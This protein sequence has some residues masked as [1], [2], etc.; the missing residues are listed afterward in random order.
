MINGMPTPHARAHVTRDRL[1]A[2]IAAIAGRQHG[3]LARGQ[4]LGLGMSGGGIHRRLRSGRWVR[5]FPGV[6]VVAGAPSSWMRDVWSAHLAAGPVSVVTHESALRRHGL[7][8]LPAHP[9]KLTMPHGSHARLEGVVVHQIDDLRRHHVTTVSGLPVSI[10]ERALVEVAATLPPRRLGHVLDDAIAA[11]LARLARID[12]CLR[13]VA[14]P[15]KRGVAQLA[16]ALD[17]RGDGYVPPQSELERSLFAALSNGGLPEP[18][19]QFPLPGRGVVR[20]LVDAAYPDV[21]VLI[22]ADGRRWHTRLRDLRRDH[23]RDTEAARVGWVTLRFVY[24]QI[25]HHPDEV[26]A[27]VADVCAVRSGEARPEAMTSG[28]GLW[29]QRGSGAGTYDLKSA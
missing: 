24:E 22:E 5:S 11:R 28:S 16:R 20:G 23:E 2:R 14:R 4:A 19:R 29:R 27:A 7:R 18:R 3:V 17:E 10:V 1:D 12:A 6:Y 9:V 26:C 8:G 25:V 15:G 21:R 13:E